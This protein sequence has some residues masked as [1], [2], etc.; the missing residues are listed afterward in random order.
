MTP[1]REPYVPP[2]SAESGIHNMPDEARERHFQVIHEGAIRAAR[3]EAEG[4]EKDCKCW[5]CLFLRQEGKA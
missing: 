5:A 2:P 4:H 1:K 3:R